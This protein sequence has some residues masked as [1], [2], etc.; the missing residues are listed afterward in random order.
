MLLKVAAY[1]NAIQAHLARGRLEA[2]GVPAF[3]C[4]EHHVW[5]YWLYSILLGGV[6]VYVHVK[7]AERAREVIAAHDRGEYALP[8]EEPAPS[9]PRCKSERLTRVRTSWKTAFLSVNLVSVPLYFLWAR[10][11][12]RDCRYKW[13]LPGT[14]TYPLMSIALVGLAVA[15]FSFVVFVGAACWISKALFWVGSSVCKSGGFLYLTPQAN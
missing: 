9:C 6:K 4:H 13:N 5:A 11:K 7:D 2:E 10:F 15:A 14:R 8:E 1:E 12:C 3:V